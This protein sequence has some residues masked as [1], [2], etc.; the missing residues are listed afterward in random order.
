MNKY[1]FVDA[2]SYLDADLL[3]EHLEKKDKLKHNLKSKRK[4]NILRWS[5]VAA[6]L[7]VFLI[8]IIVI[9]LIPTHNTSNIQYGYTQEHRLFYKGDKSISEYGVIEFIDFDDSSITLQFEKTTS[10]YVYATLCGY[11]IDSS[12][13]EKNVYLGTTFSNAQVADVKIVNNGIQLFVDNKLASD[14]PKEAGLYTIRIEY[15]NLK[16]SCEQLDIGIYISG[17]DYFVIN[18][19]TIEGIDPGI[20]TP[21]TNG[22]TQTD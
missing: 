18:P 19:F 6:C 5:A 16:E 13:N 8:A 21:N 15:S 22:T 9:D 17:F 1:L 3:A 10:D 11:G 7:S 14:F 12:S 4:V 20:L 2:V